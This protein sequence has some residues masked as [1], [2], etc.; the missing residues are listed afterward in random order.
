MLSCLTSQ[1]V[2]AVLVCMV[3]IISRI[4][5]NWGQAFDGFIP[6]KYIFAPGALYTCKLE[7]S[8]VLPRTFFFYVEF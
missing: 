8:F 7:I 6:S 5:V 3:V 2:L 1:Q 4:E